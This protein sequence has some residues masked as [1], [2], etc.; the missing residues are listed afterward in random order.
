MNIIKPAILSIIVSMVL[1]GTLGLGAS[2]S[3]SAGMLPATKITRV[4]FYEEGFLLYA[5]NWPNINNCQADSAVILLKTDA[6]YDKAYA[7]ILSGYMSGKKVY[8]YSDGCVNVD[9]TT[10]NTIRGFKYLVVDG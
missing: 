9:G 7:L 3:F 1:V 10:F 6:N 4:A 8:S 2:S 5:D